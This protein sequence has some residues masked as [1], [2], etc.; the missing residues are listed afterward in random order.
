MKERLLSMD[1]IVKRVMRVFL[2]ML[3]C[4][5]SETTA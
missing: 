1:K 4:Y 5:S 2:R 3:F